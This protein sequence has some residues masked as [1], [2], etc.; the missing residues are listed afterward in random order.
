MSV[1]LLLC[2]SVLKSFTRDEDSLHSSLY[3]LRNAASGTTRLYDSMCD[4]VTTFRSKGDITRP[5]ILI[6]VTDGNDICSTRSAYK[7]ATEIYSQFTKESSNFLFLVGVGDDVK[8]EKM[9]EVGTYLMRAV[10]ISHGNVAINILINII[11]K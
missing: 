3:A 10:K 5:W 2:I 4:L 7:C 9:E 6:V 11:Y 8:S 1:S